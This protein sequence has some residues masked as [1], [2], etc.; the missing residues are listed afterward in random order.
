MVR[1]TEGSSTPLLTDFAATTP[2][3]QRFFILCLSRLALALFFTFAQTTQTNNHHGWQQ[4]RRQVP[5]SSSS[6]LNHSPTASPR[7]RQRLTPPTTTG[8]K[9]KPLKA[10]KKANKELDEDDLAFLEKKRAG[11]NPTPSPKP[12]SRRG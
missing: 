1:G 6:V 5:T 3:P 12:S 4:P 11:T 9:A 10:A 7:H 8:G 2:S